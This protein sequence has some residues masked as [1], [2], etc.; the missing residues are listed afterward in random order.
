M[1]KK[2]NII[3]YISKPTLFYYFIEQLLLYGYTEESI[4]KECAEIVVALD[5]NNNA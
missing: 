1:T 2:F 5:E 4:G 3:K